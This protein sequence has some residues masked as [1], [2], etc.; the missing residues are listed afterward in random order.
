MI[1]RLLFILSTIFISISVFAEK[2]TAVLEK[3]TAK[4]SSYTSIESDFVQVNSS[5]YIAKEVKSTGKFYYQAED[6]V[7]LKNDEKNFLLLNNNDFVISTQGEKFKVGKKSNPMVA[8]L[9]LLLKSCVTG[10]YNTI[11]SRRN[12]ALRLDITAHDYILNITM[13]GSA[14]RYYSQVILTYDKLDLSLVNLKLLEPNGSYTLYTF[15]N[16][17]YNTQID[18][19]VFNI[20]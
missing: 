17:K 16:H 11:L 6:K 1:K 8:E 10:D 14:K 9:G 20:D 12:T 4:S 13:G 2:D 3:I 15:S 7:L 5:V 19:S 18:S